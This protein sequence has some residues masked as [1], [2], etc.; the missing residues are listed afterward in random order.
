MDVFYLFM[1][2]YGPAKP[3]RRSLSTRE[4]V[5]PLKLSRRDWNTT[6]PRVLRIGWASSNTKTTTIRT[7]P[8]DTRPTRQW[9][10]VE[11]ARWLLYK[12]VEVVEQSC[13]VK[14]GARW[15][16][17]SILLL[18]RVM[19]F[20]CATPNEPRIPLLFDALFEKQPPLFVPIIT[21]AVMVV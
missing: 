18:R 20:A 17:G 16:Y 7:I 14:L 8:S 4:D 15:I 5:G 11:S 12:C 19:D 10:I 2:E 21:L 3:R 9:K 1:N 13:G 6:N